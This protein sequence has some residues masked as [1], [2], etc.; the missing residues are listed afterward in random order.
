[1]EETGGRLARLF[2]R[3]RLVRRRAR[4]E[5]LQVLVRGRVL[6]LLA[7]LVVVVMMLVLMELLLLLLDEK[8]LLVVRLPARIQASQVVLVVLVVLVYVVPA[9]ELAVFRQGAD[10][11]RLAGTQLYIAV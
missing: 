2:A 7:E 1:M 10:Q 8:M 4:H 6:V 3:G 9:G 5:A 11:E